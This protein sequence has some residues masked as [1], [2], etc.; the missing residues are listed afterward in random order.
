M[1]R[2][3]PERENSDRKGRHGKLGKGKRNK[4]R[5]GKARS[6]K[7]SRQLCWV[8]ENKAWK[9]T[10]F[11]ELTT[12]GAKE[13]HAGQRQRWGT[14][15]LCRQLGRS[16]KKLPERGERWSKG[17]ACGYGQASWVNKDAIRHAK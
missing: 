3:G 7:K 2:R 10:V 11:R 1:Q 13:K 8:Q 14:C 12:N 15:L 16:K 6:R 17:E 9:E 5:I 4:T